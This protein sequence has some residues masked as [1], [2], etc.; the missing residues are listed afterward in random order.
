MDLEVIDWSR[1]PVYYG[2]DSIKTVQLIRRI[3]QSLGITIKLGQALSLD[4]FQDFFE[5]VE[6]TY[7]LRDSSKE[8]F[9][10]G[11]SSFD[12]TLRG[13]P[14]SQVQKGLWYIQ[15]SNPASSGFNVPIAFKIK[16]FLN[17]DLLYQAFKS[18]LQKYPILTANLVQYHDTDELTHQFL[19]LE[20]IAAAPVEIILKPGQSITDAMF[21]LL[22]EPFDLKSEPLI[23]WYWLSEE[24][25][26]IS[27]L[28]FI[29]HHIIIDG[30]S[31]IRFMQ[32]F[33]ENYHL[34][35]KGNPYP[36]SGEPDLAFF[37]Y[38]RWEQT[39]LNSN[40]AIDDLVWWKEKTS[41]DRSAF[42]SAL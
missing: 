1:S 17:R 31:G 38:V 30:F 12:E 8:T 41:W 29:I 9:L 32:V 21:S 2:F 22:R 20:Q 11:N 24:D 13:Y 16:E 25:S 5:L 28:Y 7:K 4:S 15:E 42:C 10:I 26:G 6:K 27:Y 18:V 14:I 19:P 36:V 3:N 37:D 35:S 33:W 34:L 39:Y 40:Q 23:K